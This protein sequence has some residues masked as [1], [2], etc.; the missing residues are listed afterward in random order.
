MNVTALL[1][2]G[3]IDWLMLVMKFARIAVTLKKV[4]LLGMC[5][6]IASGNYNYL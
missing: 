3:L 6:C 1:W 2:N 5:V 4:E